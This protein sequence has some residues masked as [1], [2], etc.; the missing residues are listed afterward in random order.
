MPGQTLTLVDGILKNDYEGELRYQLNQDVKA[1][2]LFDSDSGADMVSADGRQ[3]NYPI[4][5]GRNPG[6]GAIGAGKTLPIAGYQESTQVTIGFRYVYGRIQLEYQT[7][8][9][10][11]SKKGAFVKALTFEMEGLKRDFKR[12]LNRI[13]W[14]TGVGIL[15]RVNG[16]QNAVTTIELKNAGGFNPISAT[17]LAARYFIPR[18][19]IAV[20]RNATPT[21]ATDS[22]IVGTALQVS[23]VNETD[24]SDITVGSATGSLNDNDMIVLAPAGTDAN[25]ETSVNRE[26]VGLSGLIDD[27]TNLGT[28][29]GV[30][31]TT[32][33]VF[34]SVVLNAGGS[35][36]SVNL[37]QRLTD[38]IDQRG[39]LGSKSECMWLGHHSTIQQYEKVLLP[40]KR[41]INEYATKPDL[42]FKGANVKDEDAIELS[43]FKTRKERMAPVGEMYFV[44]KVGLTNYEN[45]PG[46][47][48]DDDGTVLMRTSNKDIYEARWRRFFNLQND[49]PSKCG[50]IIRINVPD[51]DAVRAE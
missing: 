46:E 12:E 10:S 4:H 50:K 13:V 21:S 40:I 3:I 39:G 14:G 37:C 32:Y 22:D 33:P 9:A 42:G 1:L 5:T 49:F 28:V 15:A 27:G 23:S 44:N 8:K 41:F 43:G 47:W 34:K 16:A 24:L 45:C 2:E 29:H 19:Y 26:P 25:T 38:I 20:I 51:I 17:A 36:F 31:R 7:I 48:A 6:V 18:A 11:E 30:S 35:D